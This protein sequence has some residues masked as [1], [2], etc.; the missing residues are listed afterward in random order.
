MLMV[1]LLTAVF[2]VVDEPF[3]SRYVNEKAVTLSASVALEPV[4]FRVLVMR[5]VE[6]SK[7]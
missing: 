7:E 2:V 6:L 4:L 5:R 3:A 1:I